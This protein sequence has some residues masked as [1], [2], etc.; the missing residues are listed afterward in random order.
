MV[1]EV[2]QQHVSH[3]AHDKPGRRFQYPL[4]SWGHEESIPHRAGLS[5]AHIRIS[6]RRDQAR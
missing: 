3:E 4:E 2:K 6:K 1:V 5:E